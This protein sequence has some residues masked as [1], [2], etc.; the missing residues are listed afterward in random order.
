M[1]AP[2]MAAAWHRWSRI[3][4]LLLVCGLL[5][6][7]DPAAADPALEQQVK[8]AYLYNFF[9]FIDWPAQTFGGED[10][11]FDL[12]ILGRDPFGDSL[13][14]LATRVARNRHIRLRHL[15]GSGD[16]GSCHLLF[17]GTSEAGRATSLLRRLR[18]SP[19]LTVSE[20]PGFAEHGGMVGFVLEG[21][22][23]RLEIN[24]AA[25]QGAGLRVSAKL[26]EVAAEV[27][28]Q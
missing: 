2:G 20:L 19:V 23:V 8:A 21:G 25:A 9:L 13:A 12:C 28:R 15:T 24:L 3:G 22:K 10:G 18:G 7:I 14:P 27:Y 5:A 1:F 17:I 16:P 4:R 11:D 6:S 26:L